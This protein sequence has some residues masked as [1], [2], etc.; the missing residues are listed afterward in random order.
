MPGA[1]LFLDRRDLAPALF[2]TLPGERIVSDRKPSPPI[3][4]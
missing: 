4:P 3:A 1:K 2:N